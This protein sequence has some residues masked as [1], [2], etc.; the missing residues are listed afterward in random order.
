MLRP[1]YQTVGALS[2]LLDLR[3]PY[4]AGHQRRVA[5]ISRSI[6]QE[7][8][9]ESFQLEGLRVAAT[10]HDIGKNGLPSE[11]LTKPTKLSAE[12]FELVKT[13]SRLGWGV[14]K[15]I[16]FPWPVA[17]IVL[18]HHERIDGSG[19]PCRLK[20]DEIHLEAQILGLADTVEAISAHRPYRPAKGLPV[21][22]ETVEAARGISFR[23]DIVDAFL[24]AIRSERLRNIIASHES[25]QSSVV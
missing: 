14:L 9:V 2:S 18:Q 3:D 24:I 12:E 19:Y 6:G 4:T 25:L 7:M 1:L 15:H 5:E 20:G 23:E 8:G 21:A 10:L 16:D 11:I 22:I 17:E 13:H